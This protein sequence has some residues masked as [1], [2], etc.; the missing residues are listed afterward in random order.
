MPKVLI[1]TG[2]SRGIGAAVAARA[3]ACGY[4][5]CVNYRADQARADA[6]VEGIRAA[7]GTATEMWDDGALPLE[8]VLREA[9]ALVPLGR[10]ATPEEVAD[11]VLRLCSPQAACVT[12]TSINV[13]GGRESN[14]VASNGGA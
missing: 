1:V 9:S 12:A 8:Q 4:G 6:V 7:G 5:V 14:V 13:S 2:G 3:G 11:V 10:T